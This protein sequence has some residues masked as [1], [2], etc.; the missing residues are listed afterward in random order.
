MITFRNVTKLYGT[1]EPVLSEV[2]FIIEKGSFAYL[3]GPTGSGKTTIFRLIIGDLA[4]TDGQIVLGE[5]DLAN[6][7]KS[8]IPDLRRRVGVVFQDL[9]LL[10]DRTVAENIMLPLQMAGESEREARVKAD[11][12]LVSVGLEGKGDK[13]PRELSGGER[14]RVAIARA[15][16]FNP[17][18]ILAD[19]PTGNLDQKTSFQ[20]LDLLKSINEKLGTTIFMATHNDVL[21]DKEDR[22]V[23]LDAGKVKEDKKGSKKP[24]HGQKHTDDGKQKT[25]DSD[26]KTDKIDDKKEEKKDEEKHGKDKDEKKDKEKKDDDEKSREAGSR[27]AG[28][29][30]LEDLA[31][32]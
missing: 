28:K 31:E 12:I 25:E 7:P 22:V 21:I 30:D 9:K 27:S 1:G 8:K 4:P 29:I 18:I 2:N 16:I 23:V 32:K 5:L 17:E 10:M 24:S 19:E 13:F 20:I 11:E 26:Q 3:V 15:L 6:L 14:Q